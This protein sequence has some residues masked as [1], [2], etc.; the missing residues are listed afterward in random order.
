[1]HFVANDPDV[2]AIA[3]TDKVGAT[4][5]KVFVLVGKGNG[6]NRIVS[7]VETYN[8]TETGIAPRS[9]VSPAL[10]VGIGA[11]CFGENI[12]TLPPKLGHVVLASGFV[13]TEDVG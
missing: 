4:N 5:G 6:S 11:K 12:P 7:I 1:V 3:G 13:D 9:I 2:A 8:H 10:I